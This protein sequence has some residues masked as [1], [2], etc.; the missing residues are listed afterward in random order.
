M[1]A[2]LWLCSRLFLVQAF[3]IPSG[4]MSNTLLAGDVMWVGKGMFGAGIPLTRLHLPGFR[5]PR[6]DEILVFKSVDGD[7]D[8]VKR[9]VG[10][11]GDTLSMAGGRLV[12]N[13]REVSEPFAVHVDRARQ[14]SIR[15]RR[16]MRAWQLPYYVG[17]DPAMYQPDVQHWGPIVV[18]AGHYF[19]MGDNRDDSRDSRYWGFLPRENV[20]GTPLMVY[21]SYDPVK[22]AKEH[23]SLLK[24]IRWDRLFSRPM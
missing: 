7:Y 10:L 9:V 23:L 1:L 18:P 17:A 11:P 4:S 16:E 19:M 13:G 15:I 14:E 6:L 8:V 20:L 21:F 24:T 2:G 22:K 3:D 5:D 12:R